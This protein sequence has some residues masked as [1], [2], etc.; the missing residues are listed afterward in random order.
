MRIFLVRRVV[1]S[2]FSEGIEELDE[3]PIGRRRW[4]AG[5]PSGP[6]SRRQRGFRPSRSI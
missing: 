3:S 2:W 1:A 6:W 4:M 5:A